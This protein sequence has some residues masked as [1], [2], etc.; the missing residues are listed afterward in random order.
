MDIDVVV[1]FPTEL[2]NDGILVDPKDIADGAQFFQYDA[3]FLQLPLVFIRISP[4]FS[5]HMM[6]S[7]TC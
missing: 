4:V 1:T 3:K 2:F 6:N 7:D 5:Q